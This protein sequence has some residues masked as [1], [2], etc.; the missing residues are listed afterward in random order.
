[1]QQM[2]KGDHKG[3]SSPPNASVFLPREFTR[4][5]KCMAK[6]P[7]HSALVVDLVSIERNQR[8]TS[9]SENGITSASP[10]TAVLQVDSNIHGCMITS[11]PYGLSPQIN[12]IEWKTQISKLEY[13]IVSK[14]RGMCGRHAWEGIIGP[15]D[16]HRWCSVN[17]R[18]R[19][20]W[21]TSH[22]A[23]PMVCLQI[24]QAGDFLL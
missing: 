21:R 24:G 22:G 1:M 10:I 6:L 13:D 4:K 18:R 17:I 16:D 14:I 12:R 8:N 3:W 23:S 5:G 9:C 11:V 2:N 19:R 15:R 7:V 20:L